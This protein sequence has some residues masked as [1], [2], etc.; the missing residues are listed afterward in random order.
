[1][2]GR[3]SSTPKPKQRPEECVCV[4]LVPLTVI[5]DQN[6]HLGN[7]VKTHRRQEA[8]G[9]APVAAH[10]PVHPGHHHHHRRGRRGWLR[11]RLRAGRGGVGGGGGKEWGGPLQGHRGEV[12]GGGGG[13]IVRARGGSGARVRGRRHVDGLA[14]HRPGPPHQ[15]QLFALHQAEH[16]RQAHS[17]AQAHEE[18]ADRLGGGGGRHQADD[19][20]GG[21]A[22]Q[23][24]GPGVDEESGALPVHVQLSLAHLVQGA[25]VV[26]GGG[27]DGGDA[28]GG[29]ASGRGAAGKGGGPPL[30]TGWR[31]PRRRWRSWRRGGVGAGTGAGGRSSCS[32]CRARTW[33]R[34]WRRRRGARRSASRG[35]GGRRGCP[36]DFRW[37]SGQPQ[38]RAV[39]SAPDGRPPLA[40][41]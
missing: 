9:V 13:G 8:G 25:H 15:G 22:G 2:C 16:A 3:V 32:S 18:E 33:G 19:D 21:A 17:Y 39:S 10:R 36:G 24:H 28:A 41:H 20:E 31:R 11:G 4:C 38:P 40:W 34:R 12:V 29:G 27:R 23:Q 14:G 6:L 1:M 5:G 26:A 37:W 30:L 7:A 35:R